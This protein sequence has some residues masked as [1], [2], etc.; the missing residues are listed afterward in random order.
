VSAT[1]ARLDFAKVPF[2]WLADTPLPDTDVPRCLSRAEV[3][4]IGRRDCRFE[5]ALRDDVRAAERSALGHAV[6]DLA[7]T[8]CSGSR[9]DVE[10]EGVVLFSDS[11]HLSA[12]YVRTLAPELLVRLRPYLGE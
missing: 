7:D 9:C 1:R 11:N 10:R 6:V 3:T 4:W 12:T 8:I 2:I 5:R